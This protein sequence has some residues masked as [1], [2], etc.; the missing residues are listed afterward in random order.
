M[1][2]PNRLPSYPDCT[3]LSDTTAPV[4]CDGVFVPSVE[5]DARSLLK[6]RGVCRFRRL[7][8]AFAPAVPVADSVELCIGNGG[9]NFP[10]PQLHHMPAL[11]SLSKDELGQ[12]CRVSMDVD[13]AI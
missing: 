10:F 3:L 6:D 5:G 1:P 2:T 11:Y 4:L 8:V 7:S 9:Q 13:S 12:A